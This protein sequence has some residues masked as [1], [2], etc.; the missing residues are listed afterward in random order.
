MTFEVSNIPP[1]WQKSGRTSFYSKNLI[2]G[3]SVT[4]AA[5][6]CLTIVLCVIWRIRVARQRRESERALKEKKREIGLSSQASDD[7]SLL[8]HDQDRELRRQRGLRR[9]RANVRARDEDE[10][11]GDQ[12]GGD[13]HHNHDNDGV[14][15]HDEPA[16]SERNGMTPITGL[17]GQRRQQQEEEQEQEEDRTMSEV[18]EEYNEERDGAGRRRMDTTASRASVAPPPLETQHSTSR[19]LALP[20]TSLTAEAPIPDSPPPPPPASLQP[21]PNPTS[22]TS[23]PPPAITSAHLFFPPPPPHEASDLPRYVAGPSAP[24]L[25]GPEKLSILTSAPE[26]AALGP[27]EPPVL[28]SAPPA[29]NDQAAIGLAVVPSAPPMVEDGEVQRGSN[30]VP[31]APPME[32]GD[33]SVGP[34]AP[35]R[36]A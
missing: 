31:S 2:I 32:E 30:L 8:Y 19:L 23:P 13:D 28:P 16:M 24:S 33:G 11:D 5:L 17:E 18:E 21:A 4:L 34:G 20:L 10:D 26:D 22:P 27:S 35:S 12:D 29:E 36:A 9:R 15:A 3:F 6:I 7:S 1:G 14:A 25:L